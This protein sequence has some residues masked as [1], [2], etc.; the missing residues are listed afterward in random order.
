MPDRRPQ[1]HPGREAPISCPTGPTKP[2]VHNGPTA[3]RNAGSAT[4]GH[5][6]D[7]DHTISLAASRPDHRGR[8]SEGPSLVG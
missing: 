6:S 8:I 2:P 4:K 1:P 5:P 3:D 7:G